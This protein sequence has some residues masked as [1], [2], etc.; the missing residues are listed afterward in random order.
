MIYTKQYLSPLGI[1]TIACDD[2]AVI[3]LWFNAQKYFGEFYTGTNE[4]F[5]TIGTKKEEQRHPLLEET[6]NWLDI[7]FSG[8][9]PN[10]LPPLKYESTRFRKIVC[11]IMLTIPYGDTMTYG[12][13]AKIVAKELRIERMSAQAVGGAVGHNPISI[14]IPCH[15][16]VGSNGNLTGYA[17]GIERKV[18][19]L[20][21]ERNKT[22]KERTQKNFLF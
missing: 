15:R 8:R 16:V 5:A 10:F 9:E 21:L 1:M 2:N 4:K 19:L 17:G 11:D 20:K 7:Y 12:E 14:M 13:I 22:N 18:K 3:G 6:K